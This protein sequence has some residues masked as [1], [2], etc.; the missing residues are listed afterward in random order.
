[1]RTVV[2][3]N[4]KVA[5]ELLRHTLAEG[6][7]VVGAVAPTEDG[8]RAQA[9][10]VP[11]DDVAARNDVPLHR[12]GDLNGD[13]AVGWL[14]DRDPD[15]C[16]CGGWSTVID[17]RVLAV[18]DRGF[19]GFHA[20][21]LPRGRGGAPVNWSLIDGADE[22]G[23]SLFHYAPEVDA[24]DVLAQ[25]SV[26]VERRDDVETVFDGIAA[27]ACRLATSVR[28]DLAADATDAEPQRIENATYRPRRQPQDGLVDW[29]RDPV[30]QHDW[31]RA[32][33]EPYPGAYTFHD[34]ER[35]TL[36]RG[37][38]IDESTPSGRPGE[39]LDVVEGAGIDVRSGTGRFRVTRV[40]PGRRPSRWADRYAR[41]AGIAP[42]DVLGREAAPRGWYYTGI[43]GP[44]EPTEF[45]TNLAPGEPG[46]LDV[47]SFA[48]SRRALSVSATVDGEHLFEESATVTDEYRKTVSYDPSEPGTHTVTVRFSV[49]GERVDTRRL[50]VYVAD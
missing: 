3:G 31:V 25:G 32:L 50:K 46:R 19:L 10:Y 42:G 37:E 47:V 41:E 12:T 7:N 35:V 2:V 8:A 44:T 23:L 24:G 15:V 11:F 16:L 29:T 4:R 43:R 33:T 40:R 6:W 5:R 20:S 21:E 9:N 26:P 45:E 48:G 14:E 34:G 38:V 13:E 49:D 27:E 18:P 30:A 22:V 36:W 28:A 1:M 17:E 39:V